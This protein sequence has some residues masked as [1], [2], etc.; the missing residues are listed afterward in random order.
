[1]RRSRRIVAVALVVAVGGAGL[2]GCSE[3]EPTPT[4]SPSA[5]RTTAAAT[6]TPTASASSPAATA[7]PTPAVPAG[8]AVT[9]VT[10]PSFP[11]LGGDLRGEVS[12][13]DARM[14]TIEFDGG[15]GRGQPH[16]GA[17]GALVIA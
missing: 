2:V 13:R 3:D 5:A 17:R 15:L 16:T 9:D 1:M 7:G 4:P 14:A 6:G 11:D 10:S 12:E 8:F